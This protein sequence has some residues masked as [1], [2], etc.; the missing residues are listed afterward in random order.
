MSGS[1]EN[2]RGKERTAE[3]AREFA[4][5]CC[6]LG[7]VF[8]IVGVRSDAK[9]ECSRRCVLSTQAGRLE[10]QTNLSALVGQFSSWAIDLAC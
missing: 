2:R 5:Y 6:E 9:R 10:L 1:G 4:G 8:D 7:D 3:M